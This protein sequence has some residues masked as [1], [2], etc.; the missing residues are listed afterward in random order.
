M[1]DAPRHDKNGK[2]CSGQGGI[3]EFKDFRENAASQWS[4]CTIERL[5]TRLNRHKTCLR[6]IDPSNPPPNPDPPIVTENECD[7]SEQFPSL[8]GVHFIPQNGIQM[9]VQIKSSNT[10]ILDT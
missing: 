7:L 2:N 4:T 9:R 1:Y 5:T 3:M 10:N 6:A 8:D